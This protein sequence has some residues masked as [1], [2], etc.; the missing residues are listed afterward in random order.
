[1][2]EENYSFYYEINVISQI[3]TRNK[4]YKKMFKIIRRKREEMLKIKIE[5]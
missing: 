1:M 2:I 3:L 4:S 5:K